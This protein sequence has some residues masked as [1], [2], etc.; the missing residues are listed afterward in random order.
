[1]NSY[2]ILDNFL[3]G[4]QAKRVP[5]IRATV[6][7]RLDAFNG[8]AVE[9]PGTPVVAAYQDGTFVLNTSGYRTS[10]TKTRIN[11]YSPAHVYQKAGV[12]YLRVPD[13]AIDD[14]GPAQAVKFYDGI[15]VNRYGVPLAQQNS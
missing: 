9:Y 15:R 4:R 1:M 10:T 12:W 6:V 8:I 14:G 3:G 13:G 7:R 11:T 5:S 2:Q